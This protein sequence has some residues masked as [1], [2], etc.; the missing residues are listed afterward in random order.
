MKSIIIV[1]LISIFAT[2]ISF[3]QDRLSDENTIGWLTYVG[4]FKVKP[5]LAIH[6]EYQWRRV[7]LLDKWQQGLARVG[8]NYS[9]NKD[10][11][12]NAGYGFA[13]TYP[14]GDY[15][16]VSSFPEHRIYEQVVLNNNIG[17]VDNSHRFTLEQRFNGRP[18]LVNNQK[19]ISWKFTN[20]LRYR[21]RTE[22]PASLVFPKADKFYLAMFEEIFIGWGKN[23]GANV[24][25]QNRIAL[26]AGYK[27]NN[28]VKLEAGYLNQIVQQG[29]RVNNKP[30]FQY[31]NG[32]LLSAFI[33]ADL[34]KK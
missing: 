7:H 1:L 32:I 26:L 29:G 33:S 17:K 31:N 12:L 27:I 6:T 24:F 5:K 9:P 19:V 18:S 20:R 8:L 28:L 30:V 4:T 15:P 2:N 25:D 3:A 23:V 34:M 21:F 16:T 14:Y 13:Y 10:V 11:S 22:L